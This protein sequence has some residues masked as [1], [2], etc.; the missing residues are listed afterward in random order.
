MPSGSSRKIRILMN[1]SRPFDVNSGQG[2]GRASRSLTEPCKTISE[3]ELGRITNENVTVTHKTLQQLKA[4][5]MMSHAL[6]VNI[7]RYD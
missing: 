7:H 4:T 2:F 3:A 5:L 1:G 6:H